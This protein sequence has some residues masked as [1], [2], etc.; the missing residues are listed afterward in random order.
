MQYCLQSNAIL[1]SAMHKDLD[2]DM[3]L[4]PGDW[5]QR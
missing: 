3:L 1:L 5:H 2:V 4:L